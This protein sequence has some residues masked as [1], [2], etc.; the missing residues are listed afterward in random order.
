MRLRCV[1]MKEHAWPKTVDVNEVGGEIV[2]ERDQ[3]S[4]CRDQ[5]IYAASR[6]CRQ[7]WKTVDWNSLV[8]SYGWDVGRILPGHDN[9]LMAPL[10]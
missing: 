3:R 9:D 6:K 2:L 4:P 10:S 5:L 8:L 1:Q 7:E